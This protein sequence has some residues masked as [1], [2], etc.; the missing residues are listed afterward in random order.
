MIVE[1]NLY[2]TSLPTTQ[3]PELGPYTLYLTDSQLYPHGEIEETDAE[4]SKTT[5]LS[6]IKVQSRSQG[7]KVSRVISTAGTLATF[8]IHV[9]N[10]SD[11]LTWI[12]LT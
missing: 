4:G 5:G 2:V 8:L 12:R 1:E 7:T 6:T 10:L 11:E 3:A 9:S